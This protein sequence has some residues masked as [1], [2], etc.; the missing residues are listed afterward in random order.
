M[1]EGG[2][3][4]RGLVR[5]TSGAAG[6]TESL[7]VR[8]TIQVE[9]HD[10][11]PFRVP[12]DSMAFGMDC[13]ADAAPDSDPVLFASESMQNSR[14]IGYRVEPSNMNRR[15]GTDTKSADPS[16]SRLAPILIAVGARIKQCR[17]AA[18][19]SQER[20]AFEASVDRT[21]ISS[22]E[23]GIANPSVETLA[24]ICYALNVTLAELFA[25]LNGVSLRP[26][27]ARRANAVVPPHIKG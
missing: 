26:T 4:R 24:N 2:D 3:N 17:H 25:P 21:Y 16:T 27:G 5:A 19:K 7:S 12:R 20:L 6:W 10:L 23:R 15:S 22:I 1:G 13:T 14:N 18:D 11:Q 9:R 8:H